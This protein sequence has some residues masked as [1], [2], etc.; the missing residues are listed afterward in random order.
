MSKSSQPSRWW[1]MLLL[2]TILFVAVLGVST[3]FARTDE[4][5]AVPVVPSGIYRGVSTAVKF[6]VSP[7]LSSISSGEIKAGDAV[8]LPERNSGLEG[9]LGPQDVDTAVQSVAGP[10]LIPG[11]LTSFDGPS[12]IANVSPPDPVGDVGPNHYV[13]MSNLYYAVYDK[14][15]ALLLGPNANNTLWAGFGG[16]CQTDNAGDPIVL[17]DQISDR[18]MLSQFTS[19]GPTYFN[20][21]AVSTSPDPTGTYYRWAFSTGINF[22]D[23]PK[24][25]FWSDALYISTREFANGATF[26][27]IG[28]YA[29]NRAELIAGNP[30]PT[31]ISFL[32]TPASAGGAYN[33]GDGLLP[34]DMDGTTL[35][36]AGT[37]NF[38]MGAMD[39]GGPYGAPQD[40]LT[41]WKFTADFTTP[42]NSS[43]V[44]ANTI[45]ISAYDSSPVFCSGR[46]CV[47]QPGTANRIDHLGYRQ[48]PMHRLA[49]RNFGSHES[50]VTNQSVEAS[51]TMSGIRWWEVR[52]PN[53]SPVLYQDST[54]APGLTDGIHR[55]MGSIAMDGDGNMALGYSASDGTTTFPSVW[56]TGRLASDPLNT[57]PQGEGSIIN[58]TGSQTGSQRWGDYTSMNVDPVDDCTFWYVNEYVPTTSSVGWRLRIGSFKFDE[59]APPVTTV[60]SAPALAI[61]DNGTTTTDLVVTD[62]GTLEDMDISIDANHTWVGDLTFIL[63]HD[64]V[65]VTMIDRPGYT[66]TGFG[67]SGDNVDIAALDDEGVDGPVE[68]QCANAPALFGNPTPNNPLSAFDGQDLS[69]TWTLSVSD[70]ANGDTGTLNEWCLIPSIPTTSYSIDLVK[71]V[72]TD[73]AVCANGNAITVDY[74]TDVTYCYTVENTGT[75]TMTLHTLEDDQLGTI[76]SDFAYNLAPGASAFITQT[77][78]L[79]ETTTNTAVW[80]ADDGV[81]NL[82]TDTDSA[83]VTVVI[84]PTIDVAPGSLNSEQTPDTTSSQTLSIS[85]IGS[86]DLDWSIAETEAAAP[87]TG[88]A[89]PANPSHTDRAGD[90]GT[91]AKSDSAP[92]SL[93]PAAQPGIVQGTFSEGFDDITTLPGAGWAQINNSSPL[94]STGWFQGNDA[95]FP[96][97]TGAPTAYIGA[98]FNNTSGTGTISNWLLTP[99]INLADGS[100]MTFYTRVPTGSIWPDRLEVRMS[101]AGSSTN[102]GATAT[103][104]GDFTNLLLEINPTLVNGGY[105]EVWTQFTVTLSGVGTPTTGRL[106]FRYFVT[107]GGPSGSNS[108]FIGIDTVE[109]TYFTPQGPCDTPS[110]VSWLSV[111]PAAGTTA[112]GASTD[113]TVSFDSTGLTAG[114]T[115]TATLCVESNDT[116]TP[117]VTVPVTLT[118]VSVSY[119]VSVTTADAAESGAP[120]T[121]VMYTV[122]ITNTGNVTDTFDVTA[123]GVWTAT[124]SSSSVT[125]GAGEGTSV[126][127]MVDISAAA[128]DGETDTTTVTATSQMEPTATD[129]VDLTT[130]AV[131]DDYL[132][133]LPVIMKP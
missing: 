14:T 107:D 6:D 111:S 41:L 132:I 128:A 8:E 39:N 78:T 66:G 23:Y 93:L 89:A 79:T 63:S 118:V 109:Y 113:V 52:S 59:C 50:L 122:W 96:A 29:I 70:G 38:F 36:P 108:N 71:T 82:A 11:P 42:A 26:A 46:S 56:Y 10:S 73:P 64:G 19:S 129:S 16:D 9:A 28:A 13:A 51:T 86:G 3:V 12:N 61:P 25:G 53:S 88:P 17:Y 85:N 127:V 24:Y 49:Y 44:L 130:T 119:G 94:G 99:E 124:P 47:P 106:A 34:A 37:P 77:V 133:Y 45:P 31:V 98:N 5:P 65:D 116:T 120:G 126:M 60:C 69:G 102:V 115:Y 30:A 84:T 7:P 62:I 54:Y 67:C 123:A 1:G 131:V 81:G 87:T 55:W 103:S 68:D 101:T 40:A 72:G 58:G 48:R 32:A 18:W 125:L 90:T 76:L 20:C 43:F 117:L 91:P 100:T 80:T 35:P 57:M 2:T 4:A 114:N 21:V 92:S 110:D 83:T 75:V 105:P 95:V 97:Q 27:G 74:G 33:I 15:G 104:V 121:S 112:M 22:P